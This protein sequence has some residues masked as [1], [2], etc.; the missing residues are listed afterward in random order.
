MPSQSSQNSKT[1][2]QFFEQLYIGSSQASGV[3]IPATVPGLQRYQYVCLCILTLI[4]LEIG[5]DA[6][7]TTWLLFTY[8]HRHSFYA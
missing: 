4:M 1:L 5:P 8:G 6:I 3:N 7:S 2:G